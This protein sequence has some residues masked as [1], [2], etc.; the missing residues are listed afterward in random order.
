MMQ[1]RSGG[2]VGEIMF[3]FVWYSI[4]NVEK[5][6]CWGKDSRTKRACSQMIFWP[7]IGQS[8]S[9]CKAR[10]QPASSEWSFCNSNAY[11]RVLRCSPKQY[12]NA[13]L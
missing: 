10:I 8:T 1:K 5:V 12:L 2:A 13:F 11:I 3:R 6:F 9:S 7:H 4:V